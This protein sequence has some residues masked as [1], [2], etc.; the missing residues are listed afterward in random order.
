MEVQHA[1]AHKAGVWQ[2]S[3]VPVP[4][5]SEEDQTKGESDVAYENETLI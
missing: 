3:P 2:G 1:T 4:V 5:L